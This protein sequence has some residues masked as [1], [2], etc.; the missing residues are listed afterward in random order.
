MIVRKT[1]AGFV[2]LAQHEHGQLAGQIAAGWNPDRFPGGDRKEDVL[3]AVTEH[4]RSWIGLD[5][6]P[7]WNDCSGEPYSFTDYP[8]L[9]KL[10]FYQQGIDGLEEVNPYAALLCSMHYASFFSDPEDAAGSAYRRK[11]LE[12]Q[13]RLRGRLGIG[14]TAAEELAGQFRLLQLCDHLSLYLGLNGPGVPKEREHSWFRDGFPTSEQLSFAGGRRITARWLDK[15][16]VRLEPFPL[17]AA[18]TVTWVEKH[19]ESERIAAEGIAGAYRL[20]DEMTR[21]CT[22]VE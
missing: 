21:I 10:L 1:A 17:A 5:H 22:F 16:R 7:V 14:G 4:D 6:T 3:L 13:A 18:L 11:E 8:L 12:R 15:E 19:V 9:P 20:T 2:M